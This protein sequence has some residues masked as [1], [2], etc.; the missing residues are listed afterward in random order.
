[1]VGNKFTMAPHTSQ[2]LCEK[3]V[4]WHEEQ[5]RE[6]SEIANL[7]GCSLRAVYSVLQLHR[8]F[9]QVTNPYAQPRGGARVFNMGDMNYLSSL[10]DANPVIYLDEIQDSLAQT[11]NVDVSISTISHALQSLA[12]TNKQ[13]STTALERNELLR[14]VWQAEHGDIPMEYCVWL[15]EASVDDHTNQRA[16]GW[17][18][19]GRACVR[20]AAF[21]RGQRFSVLPALSIDGIIALD[22]FE[23]SVNKERFTQFLRQDLVSLFAGCYILIPFDSF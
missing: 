15:D 5:G 19:V 7:A 13:V 4:L 9:G 1:M 12:V 2:E 20:R 6:P 8:E 16:Q 22:I 21:I 17:A 11:R 3:M 18:A 23:G 14:A 10:I